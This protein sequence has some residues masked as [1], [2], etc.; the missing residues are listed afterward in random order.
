MVR[1]DIL[2]QR[3][4]ALETENIIPNLKDQINIT[5]RYLLVNIQK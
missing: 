5:I 2:C 4:R 3:H 1:R